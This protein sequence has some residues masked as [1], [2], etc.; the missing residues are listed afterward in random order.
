MLETEAG[1]AGLY[2]LL[3]QV[4]LLERRC[5]NPVLVAGTGSVAPKLK[6]AQALGKLD[7]VGLDLVAAC[8][9]E[10]LARAALPLFCLCHLATGEVEPSVPLQII[11]GVAKG[12]RQADCALLEGAMDSLPGPRAPGECH[13]VG[14]AVGMVER[15]RL[16]DGPRAARPG[17]RVLGIASSGLHAGGFERAA[18]LLVETHGLRPEEQPPELACPLGEELL[19]PARIYVR[20]VRAVLERYR[21]K[22]VVHG[23]ARVAEGGLVGAVASAIGRRCVARLER[24]ALP[25][26]PVFGLIQRLGAIPDDEMF[27]TF[28]MGVGMVAVVAPFYADAAIRRIRRSGERATV[29]G[30]V[31]EGSGPA[32]ELV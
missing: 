32:V 2:A 9:N 4:G 6:L 15:A 18:R 11:R 1:S 13:L 26:Q 3:G 28:N 29:I 17:D 24:A 25:R 30:E 20:S 16:L 7:T 27:R 5:R 19:R 22:G 14:F 31:A 10:L 21:V 12:C 8:V 23:L